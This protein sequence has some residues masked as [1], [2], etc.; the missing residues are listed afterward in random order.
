[1]NLLRS[2]FFVCVFLIAGSAYA[3]NESLIVT[4]E[5]NVGIGTDTPDKKLT[6]SGDAKVTGNMD[7]EMNVD[8]IGNL[9]VEGTFTNK[10]AAPVMPIG[11]IIAWHKNGAEGL[12]LPDGWVECNGQAISDA[13]SPFNGSTAPDLNSQ[14][15]AGNRGRYLRGGN[16]S[17][18]FNGSTY[19]TDN[20]GKYSIPN[21]NSGSNQ[22]YGGAGVEIY[23]A[24][25][26]TVSGRNALTKYRQGSV[27]RFQVTAMTVVWIMRTK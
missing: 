18:S 1:M 26:A 25:D 23:N 10:N 15:Y 2:C 24:L 13:D 22:Y 11:S 4:P 9:N 27:T 17:G 16:T 20:G 12:T 3:T 14:V 8:I 5:G 7:V 21:A 6:V 19:Q